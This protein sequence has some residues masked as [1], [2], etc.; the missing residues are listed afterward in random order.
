MSSC[1]VSF[2]KTK[3]SCKEAIMREPLSCSA[4]EAKNAR[5]TVE[6]DYATHF[7]RIAADLGAN[8]GATMSEVRD[9]EW[10]VRNGVN[11]TLRFHHLI[12]FFEKTGFPYQEMCVA[13]PSPWQG[14]GIAYFNPV[15]G[16][17]GVVGAISAMNDIHKNEGNLCLSLQSGICPSSP[18]RAN[19]AAL[20][21]LTFSCLPN[22]ANKL[23]HR[24]GE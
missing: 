18:G 12:N 10:V 22:Q 6:D 2:I 11:A 3:E 17:E 4:F 19:M 21:W 1:L 13:N 20:Q 24:E 9:S 23:R 8:L 14:T 5:Q 15:F 7:K 16:V